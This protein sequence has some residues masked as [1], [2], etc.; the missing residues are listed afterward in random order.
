[1]LLSKC[2]KKLTKI[3]ITKPCNFSKIVIKNICILYIYLFIIVFYYC[4]CM[5]IY[6]LFNNNYELISICVIDFEEL[7]PINQSNTWYKSVLD[8]FFKKFTSNSKTI[9]PKYL[10]IKP[11]VKTLMPLEHNMKIDKKP[12][13]LSKIQ[14]D[15]LNNLISECEYYKN[16][17]SLLEI[18][19]LKDKISYQDL[20]KDISGIV[21]EIPN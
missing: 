8:D 9:N 15:Y 14:D 10:E 12:I 19:I 7:K 5:Y 6:N 2:N 21:K 3:K 17:T 4:I 20:I 18:Q 16:K 11:E 13:I 1:M